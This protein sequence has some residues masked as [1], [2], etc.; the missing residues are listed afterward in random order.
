MSLNWQWSDK[1]GEV[2]YEDDSTILTTPTAPQYIR[3]TP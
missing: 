3:V 1:M 2:I